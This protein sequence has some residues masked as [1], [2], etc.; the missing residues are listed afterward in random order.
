LK[1]CHAGFAVRFTT[2]ADLITTLTQAHRQ[3]RLEATLRQY[4]KPSLLICD[5]LGYIPFDADGAALFFQ[6]VSRRYEKASMIVSSN[7]PFSG[8]GETFGNATAA[9]A[10]I[11]R[12]VHH[13]EIVV[14]KGHSYRLRGKEQVLGRERA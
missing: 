1:A 11:D 10:I 5:E 14:L 3:H 8:W 13:A 7:L 2:A 9:S 4:L 12:L 6:L